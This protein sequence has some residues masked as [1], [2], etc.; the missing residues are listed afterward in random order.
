MLR[1][2][3]SAFCIA[4]FGLSYGCTKEITPGD[5]VEDEREVRELE[6][7]P[8]RSRKKTLING[9][10]SMPMMR[11]CTMRANQPYEGRMRFGKLGRP[12]LSEPT[13]P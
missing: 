11:P 9:S 10:P 2:F 1:L 5:R 7:V 13:Y 12:I 6:R 3:F 4:L 8:Q